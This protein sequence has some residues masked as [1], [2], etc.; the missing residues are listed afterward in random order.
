M[1][2]LEKHP[3][4]SSSNAKGL[5]N[6]CGEYSFCDWTANTDCKDEFGGYFEAGKCT[7]A[8]IATLSWMRNLGLTSCCLQDIAL[9]DLTMSV[10]SILSKI[11]LIVLLSVYGF[12][13]RFGL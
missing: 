12:E 13:F 4:K 7:T 1:F 3:K 11:V 6:P 10:A 8:S 2:R 5:A 9:E